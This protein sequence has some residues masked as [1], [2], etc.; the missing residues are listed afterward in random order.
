[1]MID[2][3]RRR[4]EARVSDGS[5]A[6]PPLSSMGDKFGMYI[7]FKIFA[8]DTVDESSYNRVSQIFQ[9]AGCIHVD[10]HFFHFFLEGTVHTHVLHI[11]DILCPRC[12]A[13]LVH[14]LLR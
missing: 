3:G 7:A 14:F 13:Q 9:N 8:C 12:P 6:P 10:V 1:M 5:Y 11:S 2:D 4:K